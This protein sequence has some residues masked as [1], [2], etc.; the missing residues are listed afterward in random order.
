[1]KV[2]N[3]REGQK[4]GLKV[5]G[6]KFKP[7]FSKKNYVLNFCVPDFVTDYHSPLPAKT[8][9]LPKKYMKTGNLL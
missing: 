8:H 9:N 4:I 3:V 7:C 2:T 1:M 5:L 6:T